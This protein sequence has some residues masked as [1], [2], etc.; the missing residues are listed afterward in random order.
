[1]ADEHNP[2][3]AKEFLHRLR[4]SAAHVMA[5]AVLGVYPEAK[6]AIGPA[7]DTGFYYD[8]DLGAD[9]Q[10]KPRTFAPGDLAEIE[11][12]MRQIIAGKYPFQYSQVSADEARAIFA[13]QPYKLE[14]IDGLAKGGVDEYGNE[15][16][17]PVVISTYRHDTFEDLCRGPHLDHTG[18]IPPDAFKLMTRGGRV[19]ARRRA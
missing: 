11:K 10:G 19:L 1:M 3:Q 8:F 12:R 7:I 5:E 15:A 6:I 9:A 4:H 2:E 18:Q 16:A 17:G 14:L 13:G